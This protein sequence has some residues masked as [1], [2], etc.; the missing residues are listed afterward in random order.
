MSTQQPQEEPHLT[1][2]FVTGRHSPWV[3]FQKRTIRA[4]A[5]E[6]RHANCLSWSRAVCGLAVK[7]SAKGETYRRITY[8]SHAVIPTMIA[9]C[10]MSFI[11]P[12]CRRLKDSYCARRYIP[13][14]FS[15]W[16]SMLIMIN[17][18]WRRES[19]V[20]NCHY[21]T[22]RLYKA[23]REQPRQRGDHLFQ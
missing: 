17:L 6:D 18:H 7:S 16:K 1:V 10:L 8:P 4:F 19:F 11:P 3:E 2:A 21:P 20:S 13:S 12:T 22:W 14:V 23:V 15:P 5:I 9:R